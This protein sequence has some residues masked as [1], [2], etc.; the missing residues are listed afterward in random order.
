MMQ[1]KAINHQAN[2]N[3]T[4][5]KKAERIIIVAFFIAF[6]FL[7]QIR[8]IRAQMTLVKNNLSKSV[9]NCFMHKQKLS[10]YSK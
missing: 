3:L 5:A 10:F 7:A 9:K 8:A 1:Q 2:K 6:H 4:F